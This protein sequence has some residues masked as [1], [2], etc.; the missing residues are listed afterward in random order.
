MVGPG[1][2][3]VANGARKNFGEGM[4]KVGSKKQTYE[5]F[6]SIPPRCP[7]W[8][9]TPRRASF[10]GTA[11]AAASNGAWNPR[12]DFSL[13]YSSEVLKRGEGGENWRLNL[14]PERGGAKRG[15]GQCGVWMRRRNG[16]MPRMT[17]CLRPTKGLSSF[18][19]RDW[20][21]CHRIQS[22]LWLGASLYVCISARAL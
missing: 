8:S 2:R 5:L 20:H 16:M 13:F 9:K 6:C 21:L 22:F 12:R 18:S 7:K 1:C 11:A 14:K 17:L 19:A 10:L 4:Q 3:S 15:E